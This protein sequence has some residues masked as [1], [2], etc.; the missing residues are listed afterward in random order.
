MSG[1]RATLE[2]CVLRV[3][4]EF[5]TF[6]QQFGA[7]LPLS[8]RIIVGISEFAGTYFFVLVISI[9]APRSEPSRSAIVERGP[10]GRRRAS[11]SGRSSDPS[12]RT[13]SPPTISSGRRSDRRARWR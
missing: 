10:S 9:L 5:G 4:P 13:S 12:T 6:Y 7:D 11:N 8:T 1:Q 3:V 2:Y